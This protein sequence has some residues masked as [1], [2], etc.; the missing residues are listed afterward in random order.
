MVETCSTTSRSSSL[1]VTQRLA[2]VSLLAQ[3]EH[4]NFRTTMAFYIC[5]LHMYVLTLVF[6]VYP[7]RMVT[8]LI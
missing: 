5:I 4:V 1:L 8:F 2:L 3:H 7:C 6:V